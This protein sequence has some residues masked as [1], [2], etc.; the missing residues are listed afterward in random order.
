MEALLDGKKIELRTDHCG[1]KYLFDQPT[2]N[3]RQAIW[4][5][6]LCEFDFEIKHIKRKENKVD[7]AL[8]RKVQE[9]HV[10]SLSIC[11]SELRQ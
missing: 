5:E 8:S 2:M 11:Q 6:F 9:M 4:L 7:D 1:L 10:E 3:A